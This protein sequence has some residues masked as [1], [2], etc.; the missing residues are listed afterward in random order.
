MTA[1]MNIRYLTCTLFT[2]I[3]LAQYNVDLE[4]IKATYDKFEDTTTVK[5]ATQWT[6]PVPQALLAYNLSYSAP[7]IAVAV[8][9][10]GKVVKCGTESTRISFEIYTKQLLYGNGVRG[11]LLAD[12]ERIPLNLTW[13]ATRIANQEIAETMTAPLSTNQLKRLVAAETIEGRIGED[14]FRFTEA[15]VKGLRKLKESIVLPD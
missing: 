2:G 4:Q 6:V 11:V 5:L 13:K 15:N 9:C 10:N 7:R 14:E 8:T 12:G 3:V 1:L